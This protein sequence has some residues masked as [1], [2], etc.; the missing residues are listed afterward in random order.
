[1][2]DSTSLWLL[3]AALGTRLALCTNDMTINMPNSNN[4]DVGITLDAMLNSGKGSPFTIES[5]QAFYSAWE[6]RE[7][8][9]DFQVLGDFQMS[10]DIVMSQEEAMEVMDI[11]GELEFS[12]MCFSIMPL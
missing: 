12:Y 5:M 6:V 7:Q 10:A 8:D 1:M 3:A 11:R 9:R 4:W 2:A